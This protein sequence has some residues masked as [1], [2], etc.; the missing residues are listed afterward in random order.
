MNTLRAYI[1]TLRDRVRNVRHDIFFSPERYWVYL[2]MLV[3]VWALVII[4]ADGYIF[5][6]L[7]LGID[8]HITAPE[9]P[10]ERLDK[11]RFDTTL[12]TLA[13]KQKLYEQTLTR[14]PTGSPA[15]T[16]PSE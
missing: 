1:S 7:A 14:K 4:A 3:A 15:T 16:T 13:N 6:R 11:R 5:W 12:T 10:V 2:L 8:A 9:V